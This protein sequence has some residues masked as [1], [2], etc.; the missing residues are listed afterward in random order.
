MSIKSGI[1]LA[2]FLF[3]LM[4]I[5]A[6]VVMGY[7]LFFKDKA[8]VVDSP[9][10]ETK[11]E[12]Y[13]GDIAF[14]KA[15][16]KGEFYGHNNTLN[17]EYEYNDDK[18]GDLWKGITNKSF[19]M[20]VESIYK[21][22]YDLSTLTKDDFK[23]DETTKILTIHTPNLQLDFNP[24]FSNSNFNSEVGIFRKRFTDEEMKEFIVD[25]TNQGIKIVLSNTEEMELGRTLSDNSIRDFIL[26]IPNTGIEDVEFEHN[27][28]DTIINSETLKENGG[29]E[30]ESV[31]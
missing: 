13:V 12:I 23:W 6:V 29:E 27:R 25:A 22:G 8:Q 28:M 19:T 11:A 16:Q 10:T 31:E 17:Y 5:I 18:G 1:K 7:L 9:I 14:E 26:A 2:K 20:N 15:I 24:Q 30:N 21:L 3:T 4:L